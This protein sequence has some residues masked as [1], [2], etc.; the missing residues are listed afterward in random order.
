MTADMLYRQ[1]FE[2][3]KRSLRRTLRWLGP[4]EAEDLIHDAFLRIYVA[5]LG[6]KTEMSRALLNVTAQRL[7]LN[8]LR[9]A[10]RR[11]TDLMG[12]MEVLGVSSSDDPEHGIGL[13]QLDAALDIAMKEMPPQCRR[14][15]QLRRLDEKSRSE[16]A[17]ELGISIKMVERHL[18]KAMKICRR[19][20]TSYG[21]LDV[22][23]TATRPKR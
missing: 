7:A 10:T 18:T 19:V 2:R 9:N 1:N 6:R 22:P 14:V 21:Y 16:I 4:A 5:E 20:L 12:E 3:L 13:H 11:G 8:A 23:I 17:A 15:F